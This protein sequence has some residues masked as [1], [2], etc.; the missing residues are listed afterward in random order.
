MRRYSEAFKAEVRMQM[1]PLH[2][3]NVVQLGK[4]GNG[5]VQ[6]LQLEEGLAVAGGVQ[7]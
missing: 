7:G 3:Q 6:L 1:S 4:A 5:P 2:L